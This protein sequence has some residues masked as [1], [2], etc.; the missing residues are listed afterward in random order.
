MQLET[1]Y[2]DFLN[3]NGTLN[4]CCG[5]QNN[6]N[7]VGVKVSAVIRKLIKLEKQKMEFD[8]KIFFQC[9]ILGKV[10]PFEGF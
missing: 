9:E 7:K 4:T 5:Y 3:I 1:D 6:N 2:K 8:T 10:S